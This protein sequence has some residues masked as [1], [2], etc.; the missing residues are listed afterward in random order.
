MRSCSMTTGQ[1]GLGTRPQTMVGIR[2]R[3]SRT[4]W[5]STNGSQ[6]EETKVSTSLAY[7]PSRH[8]DPKERASLGEFRKEYVSSSTPRRERPGE[9]ECNLVSSRGRPRVLTK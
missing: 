2:A 1:I 7:L 4:E 3:S 9:S 6:E 8:R 5:K